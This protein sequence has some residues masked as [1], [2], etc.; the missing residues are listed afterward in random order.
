MLA[1][2]GL[3]LIWPVLPSLLRALV[4]HLKMEIIFIL[5]NSQICH[6]TQR[7]VLKASVLF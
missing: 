5:P 3:P 2:A 4:S 6:D 1:I 7:E